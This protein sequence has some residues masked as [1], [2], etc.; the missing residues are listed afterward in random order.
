L[1]ASESFVGDNEQKQ[2]AEGITVSLTQ[3]IFQASVTALWIVVP[4][5]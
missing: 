3:Q 1:V 4:A 2:R 5:T